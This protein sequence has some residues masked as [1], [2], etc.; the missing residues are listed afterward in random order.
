MSKCRGP[1]YVW[2]TSTI[3][4]FMPALQIGNIPGLE[5]FYTHLNWRLKGIRFFRFGHKVTRNKKKKQGEVIQSSHLGGHSGKAA[6][7]SYK[8]GKK[9][10]RM[11]SV[12]FPE[13][14]LFLGS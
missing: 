14:R 10:A 13:A 3:R 4:F 8:G 11:F 9:G 2:E 7:R 12:P 5:V 1:T 6:G